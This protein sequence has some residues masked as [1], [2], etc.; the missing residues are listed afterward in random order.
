MSAAQMLFEATH[1][2][3]DALQVTYF[4]RPKIPNSVAIAVSQRLC[5]AVAEVE[6]F[7]DQ[8]MKIVIVTAK[9][10]IHC[11]SAYTPQT[12]CTN[13]D[14]EFFWNLLEEKS[15]AVPAKGYLIIVGDLNGHKGEWLQLSCTTEI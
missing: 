14:K 9:W 5:D 15:I 11:F 2:G 7:D 10:H 1:S 13:S 8:M 3:S 4:S 6:R 12:G